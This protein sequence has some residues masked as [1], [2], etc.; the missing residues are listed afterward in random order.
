LERA[1]GRRLEVEIKLNVMGKGHAFDLVTPDRD[2]VAECKAFSWTVSGNVPSAKIVH[3]REA[4]SD[5]RG[6][7]E[8]VLCYLVVERATHSR[9]RET[10]GEYFVRL[11]RERLGPVS[12]LELADNDVLS[13]LYGLP[14]S[15]PPASKIL[16]PAVS[17]P[18]GAPARSDVRLTLAELNDLLSR[19]L[20]LLNWLEGRP[21]SREETLAA[22]ISRLYHYAVLPP[23][24]ATYM[25]TIRQLRNAAQHEGYA[26]TQDDSVVASG[27]WAAIQRWAEQR[28]WPGD[29]R[30]DTIDPRGPKGK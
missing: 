2:V 30:S 13:C 27:A 1:L 9:H 28:G 20:K 26:P 23:V 18:Q 19:L 24:V 7:G 11:N 16:S 17:E 29:D 8:G 6:L 25:H 22:R 10:L 15:E 4:V 3:L 5:L 14:P 21:G 12:V